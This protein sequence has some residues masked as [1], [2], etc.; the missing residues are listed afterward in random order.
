MPCLLALD[1]STEACSVALHVDGQVLERVE[2]A[3]GPQGFEAQLALG[4]ALRPDLTEVG[5]W[6]G[7]AEPQDMRTAEQWP[8]K[9]RIRVWNRGP[10]AASNVRV[11]LT[12]T[13]GKT[14]PSLGP[15]TIPPHS[16]VDLYLEDYVPTC[17]APD[18]AKPETGVR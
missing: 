7:N 11:T 12:D 3:R 10:Y 18:P 6:Q 8:G 17:E 2:V 14:W 9:L 1:T 16:P 15:V 4:R 5:I 13:N